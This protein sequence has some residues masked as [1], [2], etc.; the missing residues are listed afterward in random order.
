MD[1]MR[2]SV[3]IICNQCKYHYGILKCNTPTC[4]HTPPPH[5]HSS[6]CPNITDMSSHHLTIS[7][8]PLS[9]MWGRRSCVCVCVC[10]C[11]GWGVHVVCC[12]FRL[13]CRSKF[14]NA[15]A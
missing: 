11:G 5:T 12:I 10:M 9:P 2:C 8:F 14:I 1:D 13:H 3:Q 4:T 7:L 6:T 15:S